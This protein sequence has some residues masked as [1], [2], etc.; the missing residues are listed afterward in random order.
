[1]KFDITLNG[2]YEFNSDLN[3]KTYRIL[4]V[5]NKEKEEF[6][7]NIFDEFINKSDKEIC[8]AGIDF[9]FNKVSKTDRE[10]ALM[11]INLENDSDIGYIFVLYPPE[12]DKKNMDKLLKLITNPYIIKILHGA[13][14]LDI[15]YLFNQVLITKTNIDNF[16]KNFYDTKFLCD[17]SILKKENGTLGCS[18][19][20]LL[21]D[22]KIITPQKLEELNSI[23]E[24]TGPIYLIHID[25]HK[26][27]YQ[28]LRYS[29]YDVLYLPQ[30]IKKFMKKGDIYNKIIPEISC[31]I[32]K[33]KRKIENDFMIIEEN[34]NN[35]NI[36]FIYDNQNIILL[37][38]I[39]NMYYHMADAELKLLFRI[40]Y[41]KNFFEIITKMIVYDLIS[42]KFTIYKNKKEK[43]ENINYQQYYKYI[44]NYES[45][46]KLLMDFYEY[47]EK[48]IKWRL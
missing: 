29:L 21:L 41:F 9:E 12:L 1:M 13:E 33:Y 32:N 4:K 34:V 11:Q 38:D 28:V 31:L 10:V 42:K 48:D 7:V 23:E 20:N 47:V 43:L 36:Y 37:K 27:D 17:Y 35:L 18:I 8:Y 6:M 24:K 25:I 14:S 40:S 22:Q 46:N 39:W 3:Y 2:K 26:L 45:V 44:N 15:P 16:C 19:Y 5:D 30:L